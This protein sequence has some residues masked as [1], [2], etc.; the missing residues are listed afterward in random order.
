MFSFFAPSSFLLLFSLSI[1]CFGSSLFSRPLDFTIKG[2]AAILINAESG[3]VLFEK[4]SLR[5]LYPASTTKIATA[6]YALHLLKGETQKMVTANKESLKVVT[7]SYKKS[8]D[9]QIP[10]YWLEPDGTHIR[11]KLGEEMSYDSLLQGMLIASGNDAAN[12]IAQGLAETIPLFMTNLNAFLKELGCQNTHYCNPHGLHHPQHRTT[13]KDLA[14]M[15]MIALKNPKFCEMVKQS[16]FRRPQTNLQAPDTFAQTNRLLRNG[17]LRYAPAIGVKTGYHSKAKKTFVGAAT[18]QGRTLVV[19]LLGYGGKNT[20]FEEAKALFE[21]AFNE[22]QE[23]KIYLK[24]GPQ[25]FCQMIPRAKEELL[26]YTKQELAF[27]YY[28]AE[29]SPLKCYLQWEEPTL[30]IKQGAKVGAVALK[31]AD[32]K[33]VSQVELFAWQSVKEKW[34]FN[35]LTN[36]KSFYHHHPIITFFYLLAGL[37]SILITIRFFKK[38]I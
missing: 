3:A 7:D 15:S 11:L 2:D 16:S 29:E 4:N 8:K 18:L 22:K 32:G 5:P 10:P 23:K 17:P 38:L 9:Y 35:W 20:I 24:K 14:K 37:L 31:A 13:A 12:V 19:V 21:L 6:L 28:P 27:S 34:P 1:T 30:P 25:K 33:V 36:L 26:T